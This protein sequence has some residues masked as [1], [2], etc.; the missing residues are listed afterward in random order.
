M[1]LFHLHHSPRRKRSAFTLIELLVVIAIIAILSVVVILTLN[2]AQLLEQSRD[3]NRLSDLSITNTALGTYLA[4]GGNSLGSSNLV[5]ISV[6]DP[7]A[8]SSAG[9]SCQG[10]GLPAAPSGTSYFCGAS[11]TFRNTDGTGWIP[12]NF[13]SLAGGSP[14]GQLPE[15]PIN[16]TSS[17]LYYTYATNGTQ[18]EVTALPESQKYLL[19]YEQ[20]PTVKDYPGVL[21]SGNNLTIDPLFST[22]G[23]VGYWPF[24]E[25]S[26]SSTADA[27]GNGDTGTWTGTPVGTN[28]TYY[29]GG[30]VGNYAG[31][32][33]GGTDYVNI[34]SNPSDY[35][36]SGP[37]TITMWMKQTLATT[38]SIAYMGVYSGGGCSGGGCGYVVAP[39]AHKA[40]LQILSGANGNSLV[41]AGPTTIVDDG[42]WH[43]LVGVFNG[44]QIIVYTDGVSGTASSWAYSV[45]SNNGALEIGTRPLLPVRFGGYID[46]V[47][48][49]NRALSAS[50]IQALYN[51]E[52]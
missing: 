27:S 35:T 17:G 23:L 13:S 37:F 4:E 19:Q 24:E 40:S 14:L 45:A 12:V 39:S 44:S 46:D 20:T 26:G 6:P 30:K 43:F 31:D 52:N 38:S 3:S 9:D 50:E 33:D 42:S 41:I 2:P 28:N 48:I 11:T 36:P 8:T 7:A 10:L 32:F 49:Y 15:D 29:T 5:Y 51:A 21:A 25:G 47:R 16:T 34:T 1:D 22:T 18:Y